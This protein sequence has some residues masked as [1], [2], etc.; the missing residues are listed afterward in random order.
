MSRFLTSALHA[1]QREAGRHISG[2]LI[3]EPIPAG[4]LDE[5]P[6]VARYRFRDL[7]L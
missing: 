7:L 4:K 5:M 6:H 2:K 1:A 3:S